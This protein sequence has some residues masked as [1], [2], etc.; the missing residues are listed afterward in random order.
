MDSTHNRNN[1]K[2]NQLLGHF[3]D[4]SYYR[5]RLCG[6]GLEHHAEEA[7]NKPNHCECSSDDRADRGDELIPTGSFE[8]NGDG[9]WREIV[10][11][12]CLRDV[13]FAV[14]HDLRGS[15]GLVG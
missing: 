9:D 1:H 14:L 12:D 8:R 13:F 10:A 11:E 3:Y 6:F 15:D 5:D 7:A 2:K 4:I